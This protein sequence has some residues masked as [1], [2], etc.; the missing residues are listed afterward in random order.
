[1]AKKKASAP[2]KLE[3]TILENGN[4]L[5][6][7]YN[8]DGYFFGTQ[9]ANPNPLEPGNFLIPASA[10]DV[11]PIF[12]EGKLTR[13]NGSEWILEDVPEPEEPAPAPELTDDQ[14][15]EQA[16]ATRNNLLQSSDWTQLGD[17]PRLVVSKLEDWQTYRQALR[18]VPQ[19]AGF[20]STINWP[21]AP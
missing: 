15:A 18:D 11:S 4:L 6:Y 5:V 2:V 13:W 17:A 20:P 10:T 7:S 1:M 21:T 8:P 3:R 19:Q 12:Q 14:K 9:E 16:R